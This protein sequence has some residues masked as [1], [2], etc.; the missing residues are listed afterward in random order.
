LQ[1]LTT[2]GAVLW[3]APQNLIEFWVVATR[4]VSANGLGLTPG[5]AAVEVDNFKAA[6]RILPETPA[7]FPQW[8][9]LVTT[10]AVCGK[11]AYDARLVAAMKVQGIERI[12][13]FNTGDFSRY[14][15][16]ERI[17]AID[18]IRGPVLPP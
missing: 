15:T 9:R 11:Q 2:A 13:T 14:V 6:L 1:D 8:E 4:P 7:V 16:G 12:L 10:Y 3:V 17:E 18:P 5:Q